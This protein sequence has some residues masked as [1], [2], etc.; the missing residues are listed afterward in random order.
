MN[1]Q[2]T[3]TLEPRAV[4]EG[5]L[6]RGLRVVF[7]P[8]KEEWKGPREPNWLER[9]YTIDDY[10]G[11]TES[12]AGDR[13]GIMHGVPLPHAEGEAPKYVVDVD[14]D[15]GPLVN[16]AV[17]MLPATQFIWG[18]A[19][20]KI[21]HCLYTC[22]DVIPMFQYK[23]VGKTGATL[24]E[25]RADKHQSMAPPSVWQKDGKR[26]QL[27]FVKSEGFTHI[28]SASKLKQRVCLAAIGMLFAKHFGRN[29]FGHD[30]RLAWGGFLLRCG[31]GVE[32]LVTMGL[33]IS[34]ACNNTE[35]HDVRT[36]LESTAQSL[37]RDGRKVK[38]GPALAKMM[39]EHGK[40]VLA[41]VNEWIGRDSDFARD[42]KGAII[43]KSQDNIKRAVDSL[44]HELSYNQ[45]S[46]QILLDGK[47]LEDPQWK[48]LY[49]DIDSNYHFQSPPDFFRL[50]IEDAAHRNSFHPVKDY[51]E[52]L[53]WDG[54]TRLDTWLIE[55]A[56]AEDTPYVRAISAIMLIAAVRRIRQPGCKYDEMVVFESSQG[57]NK[58]TACAA[59]CPHPEWFSDDLQLNLRSKELI[60]A[61]LGKWIIEASDLAG[62]RKTEIEQLKAVLSRAV[63][64]PA[65][66]A[67]AHFPV[68]RRRHFILIGT[69][70]SA[71]YLTDPT[72]GRRFWP[73][74]VKKFD[75][76]WIQQH[77][78]Q[79]WA[80][81]SVR[82][83]RGDSIRLP[84]VLWPEAAAKQE[85]RREI[86]PWEEAIR[87]VLS[88]IEPSNDGRIRV[89]TSSLWEAISI[90]IEKR[91]RFG[92]LRI[93]DTMQRLGFERSRVR[94]P[95][96][97]QVGYTQVTEGLDLEGDGEEVGSRMPLRD[98]EDPGY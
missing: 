9:P 16:V 48:A 72:G 91:D 53:Q 58:S 81:A 47:P 27:T 79:L 68:Q 71:V 26:E 1:L 89:A 3:M 95:N 67:Y 92:A 97:V 87:F 78:D 59:L 83:T 52:P 54:T 15:Y 12:Y 11:P 20:K 57:T 45:F 25:F 46:E 51:L 29:G 5:Y 77:R 34:D 63:D 56:G 43:A 65:R 17:A 38:G 28:E 60:E 24:I 36:T 14:I 39:G 10:H 2:Q 55:S 37:G 90:P 74:V 30:V 70:N 23:D 4:V 64:G 41:R 82:E 66:M 22:P 94:T 73:V 84:E 18:R 88:S 80:E 85:H 40:A 6:S 69:T 42:A 75:V 7:W 93:A 76:A 62:K 19:S 21:S 61:T 8:D 13:V 31:I 96:G 50:V 86:D 98:P 33:A 35:K 32:D 49:L 44:G